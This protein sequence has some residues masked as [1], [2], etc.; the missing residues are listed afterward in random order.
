MQHLFQKDRFRLLSELAVQEHKASALR[1]VLTSS[2]RE[3]GPASHLK[4]VIAGLTSFC[5]TCSGLEC[6]NVPHGLMGLD[7]WYPAD[8]AVLKGVKPLGVDASLE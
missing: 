1:A 4:D 2:G 3:Q 8:G 7:A 5:S 6:G